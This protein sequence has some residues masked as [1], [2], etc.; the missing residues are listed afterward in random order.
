MPN[1]KK[2]ITS[3][4]D[5]SLNSL[6]VVNGI[7]G[8][9]ITIDDWGS[10]S[11][12]L[13]SLEA[14]SSPTLQDVTDNGNTTTNS[15]TA[16]ALR[17]DENGTGMRMTNVGAFESS[18]GFHIFSNDNLRFSTNGSSNEA[19]SIDTSQHST[20]AGNITTNGIIT[21]DN[22]TDARLI[23]DRNA[24][25]NDSEI[26]FRTNG[27][28]NW[29]IGT[30]Q[31]GLE[32]DFTLRY[33]NAENYFRL[34]ASGNLVLSNDIEIGGNAIITGSLTGSD[35]TIDDWGSVSASL[36]TINSS[37]E[38]TTLQDI[39]NNGT[40]AFGFTDLYEAEA[41]GSIILKHTSSRVEAGQ[42]VGSTVASGFAIGSRTT[43]LDDQ[44]GIAN[45]AALKLVHAGS[46]SISTH[47][48]IEP[49]NSGSENIRWE[50]KMYPL[51]YFH[52]GSRGVYF[53]QFST[54][55]TG[56]QVTPR[57]YFEVRDSGQHPL[58]NYV[59]PVT[60]SVNLSTP[61]LNIESREPDGITFLPGEIDLNRDV[62]IHSSRHEINNNQYAEI[63]YGFDPTNTAGCKMDYVIICCASGSRSSGGVGSAQRVGT[64]LASWDDDSP[65][66]AT[67]TETTTL[68]TSNGVNS[69]EN[70]IFS[71]DTTG[72]VDQVNV[73]LTNTTGGTIQVIATW[74]Q[75]TINYTI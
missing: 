37:S 4:S 3:G 61:R 15:I 71:L 7:T 59:V 16:S 58:P 31:V 42:I 26:V 40:L 41:T 10:V 36:T 1:W 6:D 8:S 48:G 64:I 20:F 14:S 56:G 25:S 72:S 53:E 47:I 38:A 9:D 63:G 46:Q 34:E 5:A 67:F 44:P 57:N 54:G 19:L 22:S 73:R 27:I 66:N 70:A 51:D 39:I 13:A 30:G 75:F 35:I 29:S 24:T 50:Q 23:L 43:Q 52:T 32:N 45:F 60:A 74:T 68:D 21:V 49:I 17:L 65:I 33:N 18:S 69:T 12:S 62:Q 2:V 55:S 28:E 11:A